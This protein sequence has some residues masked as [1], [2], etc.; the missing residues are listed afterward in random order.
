MV[1]IAPWRLNLQPASYNGATFHVEVQT[2]AGGRR[3]AMHE[4]PK[5]DT[6]Y[7]EDM[8][9][10]ARGFVV[11]GYIVGP[12]YETNRDILIEQL[13]L[14]VNGQLILPT[15]QDQKIVVCDRY[16]ITERRERGGYAEI[17]MFFLEAGEDPSTVVEQDTAATSNNTALSTTDAIKNSRDISILT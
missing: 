17:E 9:R 4:F 3:I 7:A 10:R 5:R 15:S 11:T 12:N 13:E 16:S 1:E 2:R 14:E 8:G 6:P